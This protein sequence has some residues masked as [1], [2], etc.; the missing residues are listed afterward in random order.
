MGGILVV[1]EPPESDGSRWDPAG[2][3]ELGFAPAAV[4]E[5]GDAHFAVMEKTG[6][7]PD[8]FPRAVGRPSKRPLW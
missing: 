7:T 1:S 6:P 2:L 5:V 3:S 8:K 4:A